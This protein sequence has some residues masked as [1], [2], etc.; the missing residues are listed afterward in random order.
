MKKLLLLS[1]LM[2]SFSVSAGRLSNDDVS[3]I[4]IRSIPSGDSAETWCKHVNRVA[5]D[6]TAMWLNDYNE[7]Q[8][9]DF[10]GRRELAQYLMSELKRSYPSIRRGFTAQQKESLVMAMGVQVTLGCNL[11][12][13]A[14]DR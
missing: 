14:Y 7:E 10:M 3:E 8:V 5:R 2:A 9:L 4:Y 13:L 1:M 12:F 6:A 11:S